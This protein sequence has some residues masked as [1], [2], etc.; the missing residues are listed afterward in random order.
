MSTVSVYVIGAHDGPY[1]V[2]IATSVKRRLVSLQITS[3]HELFLYASREMPNKDAARALER[4]THRVLA[5]WALRGEWFSCPLQDAVE[6]IG[7]AVS[8]KSINRLEETVD[9]LATNYAEFSPEARKRLAEHYGIDDDS[10]LGL[11]EFRAK[12]IVAGKV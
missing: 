8:G 12:Q 5:K 7:A 9:W 2:G 1:K 4:H 6:T 3:Q 10:S 11:A